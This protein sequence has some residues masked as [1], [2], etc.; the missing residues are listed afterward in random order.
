MPGEVDRG[1]GRTIGQYS[2]GTERQPSSYVHSPRGSLDHRVDHGVRAGAVAD[3]VDEQALLHADLG[4]GQPDA[5]R[6]V[7][8]LEHVARPSDQGCV[9]VR[10]L[11][12]P[13]L[14][15]GITERADLVR[16]HGQETLGAAGVD[17]DP[18][19]ARRA[20]RGGERV[21]ERLVIGGAQP[22]H[23]VGGALDVD[24]RQR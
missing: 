9:D 6:V 5:G 22:P 2:P 18:E 15:H 23:A 16:R 20:R 4:R 14:Q 11:R 24:A 1:F 7:H 3:V 21:A 10:D 17:F 12:R 19:A 13:L 8:R